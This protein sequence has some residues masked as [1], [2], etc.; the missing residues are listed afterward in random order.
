[1]P[2]FETAAANLAQLWN[3]GGDHD[4]ATDVM[5]TSLD[6]IARALAG[7]EW[8]DEWTD[9]PA[10]LHRCVI[11]AKEQRPVAESD[12]RVLRAF[13][14]ALV[15]EHQRSGDDAEDFL[16]QLLTGRTPEG[17]VLSPDEVHFQLLTLLVAGHETTGSLISFCLSSS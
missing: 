17:E 10:V 12:L 11:A 2:S 4:V 16:D 8:R 3:S 13:T 15:A 1:V 9:I 5:R 6:G 7:V 14:D